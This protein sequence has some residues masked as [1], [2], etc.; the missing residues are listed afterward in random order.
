M[1][2]RYKGNNLFFFFS[3]E[4]ELFKEKRECRIEQKIKKKKS[5]FLTALSTAIRKDPTR[6]IRKQANELK[7]HEKTV[8]RVIEQDLSPDLKSFDYAI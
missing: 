3:T 7:V 2:T 5:N 6:S 1:S 4:K 8:K